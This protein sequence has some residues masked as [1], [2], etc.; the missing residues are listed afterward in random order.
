MNIYFIQ[1]KNLLFL[2]EQNLLDSLKKNKQIT[3]VEKVKIVTYKDEDNWKSLPVKKNDIVVLGA[4]QLYDVE[5][6]EHDLLNQV[7]Y[8]KEK[9]VNLVLATEVRYFD[10]SETYFDK[11]TENMHIQKLAYYNELPVLDLYNFINSWYLRQDNKDL[12]Q[13]LEQVDNF[14]E[15]RWFKESIAK[16]IFTNYLTQWLYRKFFKKSDSDIYYG[17]SMYPETWSSETNLHDMKHMSQKIGFNAIRVGEFF[18]DKLEPEEGKYDMTYLSNLLQEYKD[19]SLKVI[20]GIPSPT[21]PRWFS[22]HYPEA[23]IVEKDGQV[24][25]HGSRQHICTNN[26]IFRKKVYELTEKIAET[27]KK[28]DNVVA[29][30]IDNEFKCHVDQCYCNTCRATW[31]KWLKE[32][33]GSIENLNTKLGTGIWSETYSTFDSVVMPTKTPFEHNTGLQNAFADF[34]ADTLNDFASGE[35]QVLIENTDIP[36]IHNSSMNFNLHNWEL[37]N[38]LDAA[39]YDTYP[40]FNEYWNSPINL[41]LW[42]NLKKNSKVYLLETCSSHVGYIKNYVPPYPKKF[43]QTEIFLGYASGLSSIFF[44]PY[45][46][47]HIGVEQTHG[48]VVTAAG[49]PDLGYDDVL[50]GTKILE[51]LKPILQKTR[52]KKSKVAIV[53][54]DEAKIRMN[55]ESGGIYRYRPLFTEIYE[56][57]TRRGVSA[58]IIHKN[59]DFSQFNCIVVP[60]IR[61]VSDELLNKFKNFTAN[62]GKLILGPLTGDRTAEGNWHADINGLGKVGEWLNLRNVIQYLNSEKETTTRVEVNGQ[63]D[64]LTDLVTLF[65]TDKLSDNIKTICPVAD[66]KSVVYKDKNV[67]YLGG[68]PEDVMHSSLWDEIVDKEIKPYSDQD[69]TEFGDGIYQYIREDNE[70]VY[71]FMSNMTDTDKKY[72]LKKQ[73]INDNGETLKVGEYELKPFSNEVLKLRK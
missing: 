11:D 50:A 1:K 64:T 42:R 45:R 30:Q 9:E 33:Y 15:L 20:L 26:L 19:N 63:V 44:W 70:Y 7:K 32:K 58:E 69:I 67:F 59:A 21:P 56:A 17:A 61:N 60:F 72:R 68:L 48:A 36:V 37:F 43:L 52:I 53:Y 10:K 5:Y 22:Q 66:N 49:T 23:R 73:V 6:P 8:F 29:F 40:R 13:K 71:L 28:F 12:N 39:G 34:T 2:D 51:N 4:G 24:E 35:V 62:G 65:E 3:N 38:Q 46:G 16:E 25:E 27:A 41:S 55:T 47:Q 18:W 57:I 54:S 14:E 31:H